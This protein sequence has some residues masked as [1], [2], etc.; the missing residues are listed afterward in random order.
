METEENEQLLYLDVLMKK[1]INKKFSTGV[2]KNIAHIVGCRLKPQTSNQIRIKKI[3]NVLWKTKKRNNTIIFDEEV[4][5][6]NDKKEIVIKPCIQE[7]NGWPY[8]KNYN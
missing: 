4:N 2:Y 8:H 1:Q 3:K 7:M 5:K 6:E